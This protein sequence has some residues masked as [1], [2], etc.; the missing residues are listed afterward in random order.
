MKSELDFLYERQLQTRIRIAYFVAIFVFGLLFLRLWFLQVVYGN[1][2]RDLSENNR[3]RTQKVKAPRGF[4]FDSSSRILASNR[5]SFD[6]SLVPQDTRDLDR[7]LNR[8]SELLGEEV[9]LLKQKVEQARGR[10]PFE[11]IKLQTDVSREIL[12]LVLTHKLD[13]PGVVV[14]STPVRSY[15]YGSLASHV[16]GH[17]GE[18]SQKELDHFKDPKNIKL[19]QYK[20][21]Q[22]KIGDFVGKSGVEQEIEALLTGEDGGYQ[23]EVNAVGYK[24]N[25]MGRLDPIPGHNVILTIDAELQKTA[26]EELKGKVGAVVAV[27][28]RNGKL[29]TMASSPSFDPNLFSLGI[30]AKDW[31]ELINNPDHPLMNRCIQAVHPP[32]S[33][34]K[35]VT[36]AAALEESLVTE[37]TRFYCSGIFKLGNRSFRCW[38]RPGHEKVALVKGIAESCDVYFYQLGI[39][40]GPDLLAGYAKGFGFGA[41]TGISLKNEKSGFIPTSGWYRKRYGM[42]WQTG[43]SL[44]IAIGQGSNLVTPLQM[45]MAYAAMANGGRLYKPYCIDR[46]V[47]VEGK[48]KEITESKGR[49]SIPLSDKNRA[50]LMKSLWEVVNTPSG[51]GVLASIPEKDVSGKTG[52]AQVVSLAKKKENADRDTFSDHAWFAAYAPGDE[53]RIAV[54]VFIEHGGHG[55]SAA[56]PIARTLIS[57]FFELEKEE[58]V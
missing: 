11:P 36:A 54:V 47:T 42:P 35:L 44:S 23:T 4:I 49:G 6:I 22:Y 26:E 21:K 32:G 17:M 38:K 41:P 10:P 28:P 50:L 57:R 2:Y 58:N 18:I 52:T 30:S 25:I 29:L 15:P 37:A 13:L 55:G 14:E 20:G 46:V 7:V 9:P 45:V 8:L 53:A 16:L 33:T 56:A 3:I 31:D 48:V 19:K 5:P 27:D 34:Y 39:L 43:E 1:N 40:L 51:T 12:G 24:I